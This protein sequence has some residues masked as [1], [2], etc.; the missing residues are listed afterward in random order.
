MQLGSLS[1]LEDPDSGRV[2]KK[3]GPENEDVDSD[4]SLVRCFSY[5]E[6]K[7]EVIH[8]LVPLHFSVSEAFFFW[9]FF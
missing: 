7:E 4:R 9:S 3:S 2:Q 1:H 6:R 5:R 8:L